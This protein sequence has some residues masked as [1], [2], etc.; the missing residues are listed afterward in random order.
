MNI[1]VIIKPVVSFLVLGQLAFSAFL[2]LNAEEGEG[3][4]LKLPDFI[5]TASKYYE[6]TRDIAPN[7]YISSEEA[8]LT[9]NFLNFEEVLMNQPGV[10]LVSNGGTGSLT[11]LFIRGGESNH[12]SILLNGRRLPS[13]QSGQYDLGQLSLVNASSVE[14]ILGDAS[15]LYGGGSIGGVIN[16]RSDIADSNI[17]ESFSL[18]SGTHSSEAT[19]SRVY[20]E[21]SNYYSFGISSLYDKGYQPNAYFR[22][23]AAN[24]YYNK[25][26]NYKLSMDFQLYSYISSLGVPGD[27]NSYLY[28]A[29]EKNDTE[30][31]LISPGIQIEL[32]ENLKYK[33][34]LNYTYNDLIALNTPSIIFTVDNLDYSYLEETSSID[35]YL[36]FSNPLSSIKSILGFSYEDKKYELDPIGSNSGR[37]TIRHGYKTKSVYGK[38]TMNINENTVLT[39]SGRCSRFS[40]FFESKES[41]SI[42][43]SRSLNDRNNSKI[44]LSSSYG[45]TPLDAID[46]IYLSSVEDTEF[47]HE[48][49]RSN[50]IGFKTY[51]KSNKSEL[52]FSVFSNKIYDIAD[53]RDVYDTITVKRDKNGIPVQELNWEGELDYSWQWP[54][55]TYVY[56]TADTK[57][58]GFEIYYKKEFMN[59]LQFSLGYSYLDASITD[60][61]IGGSGIYIYEEGFGRNNS[62]NVYSAKK[63]DQV[64]RRPMHKINLSLLYPINSQFDL[65]LNVMGAFDREDIKNYTLQT[66]E[67]IC[68]LRIYGNYYLSDSGKIFFTVKN[69]LNDE[70]D[71]T[72]GYPVQPRSLDIGARFNF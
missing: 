37:T 71:W 16:I 45:F 39:L 69:V 61:V 65:G 5:V 66:I 30:T 34:V 62:D 6:E 48:I 31:Y 11:S 29:E 49:I 50:V 28:P 1:Q 56:S 12:T 3:K 35:N 13:G 67:D 10:F 42:D 36:I 23:N 33:S 7:V 38:S 27:N 51:N 18:R 64:I 55:P 17:G 72:P 21:G 26:L 19:Y 4:I 9:Q 20:K 54:D 40:K 8:I 70:Y 14:M 41:G 2:M 60:G 25:V 57:Q 58:K 47:H 24:F 53:F 68:N 32:N 52:G 63:G 44:F 22:R 46:M 59:N 43:I 15:S